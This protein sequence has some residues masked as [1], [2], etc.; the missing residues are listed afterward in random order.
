MGDQV[1]LVNHR[2]EVLLADMAKGH[3]ARSTVATSAAMSWPASTLASPGRRMAAG[4]P[5]PSASMP[6]D[7]HQAVPCR[8][9]RDNAGDESGALATRAPHSTPPGAISTS[10]ASAYFDPV[11]DN[12]LF[13]WRLPQGHAPVPAH[14]AARS[15]VAIRPPSRRR[16]RA[17]P[18]RQLEQGKKDE[19]PLTPTPRCA[20][21]STASPRASSRS[22]CRR[23]ATAV[24]RAHTRA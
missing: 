7:G 15:H 11:H 4:S 21:I 13:D 24:C 1:A 8:V 23:A 9:R 20:S 19:Q 6:A 16:P 12:L 22:R 17:R 10:S 18:S 14:A 3:C 2:N 5:T